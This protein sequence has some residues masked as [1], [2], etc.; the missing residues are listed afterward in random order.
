MS[1]FTWTPE[2]GAQRTVTPNVDVVKFGDGYENRIAK[3][4][5]F[6]AFSWNLQFNYR[7]SVEGPAILAFLESCAGLQSFDWQPPGLTKTYKFVCRT[8]AHTIEKANLYTIQ[9]TFERVFEP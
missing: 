5:N 1:Q 4:I 6:K 3:G 7:D 2:F 8:W 9:A